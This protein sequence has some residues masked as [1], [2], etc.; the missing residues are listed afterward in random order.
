MTLLATQSR[1]TAEEFFDWCN[2]PE[3]RDR[4]FELERGE[5][6]EMSRPG[7][8]HGFVCHN[9]GRILGNFA[10]LRRQGYACSNDTGILLARDPDTVRGPDVVYYDR[11]RRY[12][13][14]TPGY[15][16]QPPTLAVEVLSP[17]DQWAKVTRRITQFLGQGIKVIWLVD[18]EG[19]SL[20]VYRVNQLPQVFE[21]ADE[22]N[23]E[24]ELPE[25]RCRVGE[26]FY[27]PG[28]EV[29]STGAP[30]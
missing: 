5:V 3:N 4:H 16:D 9:V 28:E 10:Y 17:N 2:R 12:D 7:E 6:V 1:M 30:T 21:G 27:L 18:P 29:P 25:F 8:R 14:L 11:V 20:T 22:L 13:D 26:L 19:R 23:G 24:P 15:S